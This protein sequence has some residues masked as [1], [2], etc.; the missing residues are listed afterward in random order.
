MKRHDRVRHVRYDRVGEIIDV[1]VDKVHLSVL[2]DE[3]RMLVRWRREDVE[4][5]S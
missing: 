2:P 1:H 4:V 3:A 5:L